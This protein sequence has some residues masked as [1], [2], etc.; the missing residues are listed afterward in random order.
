MENEKLIQKYKELKKKY[1]VKHLLNDYKEFLFILESPHIDEL[2]NEAPVSGSSGKTMSKVLFGDEVKIPIGIKLKKEP[3]S[4]I[5]IMNIC[6][7]PMQRLAYT[8]KKVIHMYGDLD[9]EKYTD[10]F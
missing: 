4:N 1:K 9:I 6:S 10:F 8:N 3:N 5:G 2:L 7:I